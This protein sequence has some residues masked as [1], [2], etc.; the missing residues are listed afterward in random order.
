MT[1]LQMSSLIQA[2][3]IQTNLQMIIQCLQ[4]DNKD[5]IKRGTDQHKKA[6]FHSKEAY[7]LY[8]VDRE[9]IHVQNEK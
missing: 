3:L 2:A 5:A 9:N 8:Y 7:Q 4:Q 6:G 1:G